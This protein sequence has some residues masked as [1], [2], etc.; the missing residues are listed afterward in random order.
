[1]WCEIDTHTDMMQSYGKGWNPLG[2]ALISCVGAAVVAGLSVMGYNKWKLKQK[3]V[4]S[5]P[6]LGTFKSRVAGDAYA[7]QEAPE[8]V[9]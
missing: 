9:D 5:V 4:H 6:G 2:T 7:Y 1:M 8:H 3:G